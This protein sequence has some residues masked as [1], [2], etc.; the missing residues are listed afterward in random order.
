[1]CGLSGVSLAGCNSLATVPLELRAADGHAP[2]RVYE[3]AATSE[4]M[5]RFSELTLRGTLGPKTPPVDVTETGSTR[6]VKLPRENGAHYDAL[7]VMDEII[8]R[9]TNEAKYY[10]RALCSRCL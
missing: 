1:L 9:H 3:E 7:A 10:A 6:R 2:F 5:P 4:R 8:T